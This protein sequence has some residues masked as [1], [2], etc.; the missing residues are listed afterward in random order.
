MKT[1]M[2][3]IKDRFTKAP[4][5]FVDD[6]I[7]WL[8]AQLFKKGDLSFT[9]NGATVTML[10]KSEDEIVNYITKKQYADNLLMEERIRVSDKDKKIVR[11][12]MKE[13]FGTSSVTDD[14]DTQM[15][16]FQK[17]SE[18]MYH[19]MDKLETNY[20]HYSYP[21]KSVITTGKS[22]LQSVKQYTSPKEFFELVAKKESDFLDLAEDYEPIKTFF[23]GEQQ[24]IFM[25]TLDMLE[26]YEDSKTYIV[27]STLEEIVKEMQE[28]VKKPQ[29]YKDIPKLPDLRQ[30][31]LDAYSKVLDAASAP[32]MSQIEEAKDRVV[33]VVD[34]KEYKDEKKPQ[35]IQLF[36]EIQNGASSCNNVS[37]LRSYADKAGALKIRLL[38]EMDYLDAEL[39]KKKAAEEAKNN[40]G[41]Q[42]ADNPV[43]VVINVPVKTTKTVPI[44]TVTR[45]SSWRLESEK[46]I[47]AYLAQLKSNLLS[48]L[49]KTDIVNV[50]F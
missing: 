24:Q 21:G 18:N 39:A 17:Y 38:N 32:V 47:D 29:P 48:E 40:D 12:V 35:Y 16:N 1:S 11:G 10:N 20:T 27:D 30:R 15:K 22:L 41:N 37:V 14:E 4:Y 44:K 45:T 46:D 34:T 33:E 13:L 50:E 19:E 8:V 49:E 43:D 9:V 6:D 3:S 36:I 5:G 28:I 23:G 25:R 7:H 26:I 42:G 31:F 2:K